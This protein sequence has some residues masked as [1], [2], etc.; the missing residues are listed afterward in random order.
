MG[1]REPTPAERARTSLACAQAGTLVT[2]GRPSARTITVV[3]VADQVEARPVVLLDRGSSVI[4]LLAACPVVTLAVA[5]PE[6]FRS[7]TLTGPLHPCKWDDPSQRAYRLAPLSARLVGPVSLQVAI[8][9]LTAARPD[10]LRHHAPE[11][12]EH[13]EANHADDLLAGVRAHLS[14][15]VE[16]VVPRTLDRYGL[17]LATL[18]PNGV[19]RIRLPFPGGP[20]DTIDEVASGIKSLLTCSCQGHDHP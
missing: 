4:K 2:L 3:S 11:V 6:P 10:P 1:R 8:A 9:E 17:G 5:G 12:V 13:L 14:W 20:V 19:S 7:F 16:A 15:D 18:S